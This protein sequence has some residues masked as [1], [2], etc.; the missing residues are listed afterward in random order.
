[1]NF[2]HT[3]THT[4]QMSTEKWS[5]NELHASGMLTRHFPHPSVGISFLS[6]R[7]ARPFWRGLKARLSVTQAHCLQSAA[8]K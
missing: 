1:M 7:G 6:P 8:F 4:H 3:R 5:D 2:I